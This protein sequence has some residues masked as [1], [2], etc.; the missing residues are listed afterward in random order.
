MSI[1]I[2]T[3][4]NEDDDGEYSFHFVQSAFPP[5][6]DT[7][8]KGCLEKWGILNSVRVHKFRYDQNWDDKTD[9][10]YKF[11]DCFLNSEVFQSNAEV[12]V[13]KKWQKMG[14]VAKAQIAREKCTLTSMSAFD[15]LLDG[16]IASSAGRIVPC[17]GDE[18][19]GVQ[20]QTELHKALLDEDSE[21]FE[22]IDE[23]F[24]REFLFTIFQHFV[25]GGSLCQ[26]EDNVNVYVD[27]AKAFYKDL[28]SVRRNK[29]TGGI[30]VAS[31]VFKVSA[32]SGNCKLFEP[33][34]PFNMAYLVVDTF[35]R[36][37][38]WYY[39]ARGASW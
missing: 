35:K 37:I 17:W 21:H 28:L 14:P 20:V 34:S 6:E 25:I 33:S 24:R 26:Y 32:V 3:D 16:E 10:D 36:T 31:R 38:I 29:N 8:I 7:E 11:L 4:G 18:V 9:K 5:L 19:K 12:S 2:Q 23:D 13:N 22:T 1:Q 27:T 39:F 30:E 15:C